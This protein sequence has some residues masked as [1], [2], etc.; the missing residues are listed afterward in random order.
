MMDV[1]EIISLRLQITCAG[2][3][4]RFSS[5]ESPMGQAEYKGVFHTE[6]MFRF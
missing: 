5:E 3:Q 1:I 6:G 2:Y 4:P